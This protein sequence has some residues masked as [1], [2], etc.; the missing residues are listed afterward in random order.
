MAR[1]ENSERLAE[2]FQN[3]TGRPASRPDGEWSIA[4]SARAELANSASHEEA[5]DA[6]DRK[7]REERRK[8]ASAADPYPDFDLGSRAQRN[9]LSEY[10]ER[11]TD[12]ERERDGIEQSFTARREDI[13][14]V[15]PTLSSEF[16]GDR[17][18]TE[19]NAFSFP[20]PDHQVGQLAPEFNHE[21]GNAKTL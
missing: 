18:E 3:R 2:D 6:H 12:W 13:R 1:H 21:R 4:A 20:A 15:G 19:E 5:L 17:R 14:S 11:R 7:W 10:E 16:T 8:I 9:I